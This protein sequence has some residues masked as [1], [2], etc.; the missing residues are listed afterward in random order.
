MKK[1]NLSGEEEKGH[2]SK[3]GDWKR[4]KSLLNQRQQHKSEA[5]AL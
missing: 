4:G 5:E 2:A 1:G 3:D